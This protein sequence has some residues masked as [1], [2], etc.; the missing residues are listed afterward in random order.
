M[1]I[2]DL[3]FRKLFNIFVNEI[4]ANK[5]L[6]MKS[7]ATIYKLFKMNVGN[8]KIFAGQ[9]FVNNNISIGD[10]TFINYNCVFENSFSKI[11]IRRN[12]D[13]AMIV[14]FCGV[15]HKFGPSTQR[16]GAHIGEDI[17]IGDGSWIGA[18][19]VI[20]PGVTIGPGC[21]IAAGSVVTKDC[22][23][24]SLYMGVPAKLSKVLD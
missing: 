8:S 6:S 3:I 9:Y 7:R 23:P 20:L 12:C 5:F 19:V 2:K 21:I 18:N 4:A 24:N 11:I 17:T 13:I 16:A 1:K 14:T 10:G 22:E 15:T